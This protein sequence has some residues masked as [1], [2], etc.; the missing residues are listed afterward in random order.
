MFDKRR[1]PPDFELQL[2]LKGQDLEDAKQ[3]LAN[4]VTGE[5]CIEAVARL[6]RCDLK[7]LPEELPQQTDPRWVKE[8]MFAIQSHRIFKG[9]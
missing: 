9:V 2:L 8:L 5:E 6:L 3:A 4:A 7:D 1:I